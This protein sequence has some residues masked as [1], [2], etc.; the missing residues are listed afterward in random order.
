MCHIYKKSGRMSELILV[1]QHIAFF[2]CYI[3]YR[4]KKCLQKF[5]SY[6]HI[7]SATDGLSIKTKTIIR[8]HMGICFLFWLDSWMMLSFI[9]SSFFEVII[10]FFF[11][12]H[13]IC[14]LQ[15]LK[16][17]ISHPDIHFSILVLVLVISHH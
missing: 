2:S 5:W 11:V 6:N 15:F 14:M 12:V 1:L 3:I 9:F 17:F 7:S 4:Q 13:H 8:I 10:F 16:H